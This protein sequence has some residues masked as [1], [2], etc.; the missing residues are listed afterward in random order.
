MKRNFNK[1]LAAVLTASLCIPA[2]PAEYVP[3][4]VTDEIIWSDEET[5]LVNNNDVG[6]TRS[7]NFNEGW[8]FY[9]GDSGTAQNPD[10]IDSS[11]KDVNLPH[12]FSI[13]QNFT[14]SYE[15][16]S[17]FLPGSMVPDGT[18][19]NSPSQTPWKENPLF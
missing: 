15:A 9:L 3:A 14:S 2:F 12:D 4:A 17:G 13:S 16:E 6:S 1:L 11:W 7:S 10:F 18:A 5:V 8:K 19:K